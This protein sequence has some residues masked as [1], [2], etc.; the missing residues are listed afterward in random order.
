MTQSEI[1]AKFHDSFNDFVRFMILFL[2]IFDKTI[3][4]HDPCVLHTIEIIKHD[5]SRLWLSHHCT[6]DSVSNI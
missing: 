2:I 1:K 3:V 6:D 4:V 5:V